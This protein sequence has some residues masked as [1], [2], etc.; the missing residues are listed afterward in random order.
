MARGAGS[1]FETH[2]PFFKENKIACWNW[3]LVGGRTQTYFAW[4]SL[5]GAPEPKLWHHDILRV[6]GT[7]FHSQEVQ[8]I[9]AT[10]GRLPAR[11]LPALSPRSQV[12]P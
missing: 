2:L 11:A 6:D 7:P 3:G 9:K 5:R 12:P 10:T 8:F 1:R 4:G